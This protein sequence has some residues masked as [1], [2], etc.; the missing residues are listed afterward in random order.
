VTARHASAQFDA[1]LRCLD[2]FGAANRRLR[3]VELRRPLRETAGIRGGAPAETGNNITCG[4]LPSSNFRF[5]IR[6][7]K[8][9]YHLPGA[10][11]AVSG[12]RTSSGSR[13]NDRARRSGAC[14][15]SIFESNAP[16]GNPST[17]ITRVGSRDPQG[18]LR[19]TN[20]DFGLRRLDGEWSG[21]VA[22][23]SPGGCRRVHPYGRRAAPHGFTAD[24]G[25][26]LRVNVTR[27]F[28][29]MELTVYAKRLDDRMAFYLPIPLA[30]PRNPRILSKPGRPALRYPH[31][32]RFRHV[33][34]RTRDATPHG[35][36]V[37]EISPM[38]CVPE[39]TQS[40]QSRWQGPQTGG[41]R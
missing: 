34:I 9:A 38:A 18:A 11:R 31:I 5:R 40:R 10:A 3:S 20:G 15:I 1:C 19:L 29:N 8:M 37:N 24:R 22:N 35:T 36:T 41:V 23:R 32:E 39:S 28:D 14:G 4:G 13:S 30:D 6:R 2:R 12:T 25:G 7:R 27:R 33:S 21:L 17:S 16:G 26:Q